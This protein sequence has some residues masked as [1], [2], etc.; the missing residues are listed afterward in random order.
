MTSKPIFPPRRPASPVRALVL[1]ALALVLL[2][3]CSSTRKGNEGTSEQNMV[4]IPEGAVPV[5]RLR[6]EDIASMQP[7]NRR[8]VVVGKRRK[9]YLLVFARPCYNLSRSE[10]LVLDDDSRY[11]HNQL[12]AVTVNGARCALDGIYQLTDEQVTYLFEF[13]P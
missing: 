13:F 11:L 10:P 7:V 9:P 2:S 1:S 12:G 6:Y 8:M 4:L 3:A 5:Q